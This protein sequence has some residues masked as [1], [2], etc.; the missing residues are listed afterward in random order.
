MAS[1]NLISP[2]AA[3]FMWLGGYYLQPSDRA[4]DWARLL[5][6]GAGHA[7]CVRGHC[8]AFARRMRLLRARTFR[9][10]RAKIG[11]T[12]QQHLSRQF[13]RRLRSET[14]TLPAIAPDQRDNLESCAAIAV[15]ASRRWAQNPLV[16]AISAGETV[17]R[18]RAEQGDVRR[19]PP[20]AASGHAGLDNAASSC[21]LR[22]SNWG[23]MPQ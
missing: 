4:I 7:Y 9:I 11:G 14:V 17:A 20:H 23:P 12:R 6:I 15:H 8:V 21:A 18:A 2:A 10:R 3:A 22:W 1:A 16:L 13:N 19:F 5:L